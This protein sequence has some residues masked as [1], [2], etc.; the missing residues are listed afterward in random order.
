MDI[1]A[2]GKHFLA[3][4]RVGLLLLISALAAPAQ[5]Q[6]RGVGIYPGN[7]A[8]DYSPSFTIDS[9]HYRNLAL[10]RAAYQSGSYDYNLTAQLITDGIIDTTLPGWIVTTSSTEGVLPRN[11]REWALDRHPMSRVT[12]EGPIGS[13][14]VEMAGNS[15][16][17]GQMFPVAISTSIAVPRASRY[18]TKTIV[19]FLIR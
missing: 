19:V 4:P 16:H 3:C 2:Q 11:E 7:P 15:P 8:E 18:Q 14:Q 6:T 17:I 1:C 13:L 5:N 12:L 10:H 9:V